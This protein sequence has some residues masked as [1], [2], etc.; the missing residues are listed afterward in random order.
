MSFTI[1]IERLYKVLDYQS[2]VLYH[3]DEDNEIC[4]GIALPKRYG[5]LPILEDID[6]LDKTAYDDM[7]DYFEE[8]K[9]LNIRYLNGIST[10]IRMTPCVDC[11]YCDKVIGA[12]RYFS[13]NSFIDMCHD[14]Y[15]QKKWVNASENPLENASENASENNWVEMYD[16]FEIQ[17]S[18]C[19]NQINEN[20]L[21]P[22][23]IASNCLDYYNRYNLCQ[24]CLETVKGKE[25]I[26]EKGLRLV[27]YH[28]KM[29]QFRFGSLLDWVP[30]YK[31]THHENAYNMFVLYNINIDSNDYGKLGCCSVDT[32][33]RMGYYK[34]PEPYD[35]LGDLF[36]ELIQKQ[37][38]RHYKIKDKF[39]EDGLENYYSSPL[40]LAMSELGMKIYFE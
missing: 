25:I 22:F 12:L 9:D 18:M 13:F 21:K 36:K 38:A 11:Y 34:F 3:F 27:N 17:C 8:L 14:C 2:T 39:G 23:K 19:R 33:G 1:N 32:D 40:Q 24:V 20:V 26:N 16:T 37:L 15:D 28:I 4:F 7:F 29:D 5:I 35:K 30:I 31:S 10:Q 6:G